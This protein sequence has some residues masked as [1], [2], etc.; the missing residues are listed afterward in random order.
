M[1]VVDKSAYQL[2]FLLNIDEQDFLDRAELM[3]SMGYIVLISNYQMYFRLI[4]YFSKYTKARLGLIIG[5]TSVNDIFN[6][7][8]YR[9]LNGGIL[10][11]FG[12]LFTRDLKMYL[13][14]YQENKDEE[15][16]YSKN[17]I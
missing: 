16:I 7:K 17:K 12:I 3:C 6:E 2:L 10:E 1:M 4:E 9:N 14:P 11:A 13:Y 8:Y 15:L 5:V